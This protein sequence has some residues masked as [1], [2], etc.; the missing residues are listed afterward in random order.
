MPNLYIGVDPGQSGAIAWYWNGQMRCE[1]MP[2]T[3]K[4]IW[5]LIGWDIRMGTSDDL[6]ACLEYVRTMPNQGISSAFTFGWGYGG[7]RMALTAAEIPFEDVIPHTWQK[8]LGIPKRKPHTKK[9]KVVNRKGKLVTKKYGG[10][11]GSQWKKRLKAKAQ[12]L[13]PK[14]EIWS[15]PRSEGKQLAV[16]DAILIATYCMRKQEGL[17]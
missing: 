3:E 9:K 1:V 12:Q 2:S 7:L 13:Y 4:D 11:T 17:L 6:F 15:L 16:A 5:D 8:A 14:L 10:E